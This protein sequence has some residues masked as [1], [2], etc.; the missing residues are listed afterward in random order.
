MARPRTK[1]R[2]IQDPSRK[3]GKKP[4]AEKAVEPASNLQVPP[5]LSDEEQEEF[6]RLGL[7]YPGCTSAEMLAETAKISVDLRRLAECIKQHGILLEGRKLN[8][9][10]RMQQTG[11]DQLRKMLVYLEASTPA[12]STTTR[13]DEVPAI[14]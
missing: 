9:A 14:G 2:L 10:V 4:K 5:G 1:L 8:P 3:P 13:P 11:R 6:R 7:Q 12:Q